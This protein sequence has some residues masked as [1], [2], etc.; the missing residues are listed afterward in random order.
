MTTRTV[1]LGEKYRDILNACLIGRGFSPFYLPQNP[2][3]DERLSYH[4]D[5]SAMKLPDKVIVAAKHLCDVDGFRG[6]LQNAGYELVGA[7]G[8][9]GG[10]Y[11]GDA[12]LCACVAGDKLFCKASF[13]DPAVRE[14]FQG[15]II[16][17]RQGYAN[18]S[19]CALPDGAII[20]ADAGIAASASKRGIEALKIAPG[21]IALSGFEYGFIGGAAFCCENTLYFTG[22]L[23]GHP[24]SREICDF[25]GAH[26]VDVCF[27]TNEPAFDIGGAVV[28]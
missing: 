4:A 1:L 2:Y 21:F 10:A 28:L 25:A 8:E 18:C 14:R 22:R 11:P 23:G 26:G 20:T 16:D 13:T 27:L 12:G 3:V 7:K 17:V 19:I 5:L 15:E 9:Q 6:V 24:F